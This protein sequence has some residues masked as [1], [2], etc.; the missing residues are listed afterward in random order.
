MYMIVIT[1]FSEFSGEEYRAAFV[2]ALNKW[3]DSTCIQFHLATASWQDHIEFIKSEHHGYAKISLLSRPKF[4]STKN[5]RSTLQTCIH[6]RVLCSTYVVHGIL[7]YSVV[8]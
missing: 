4:V 3:A 5:T 1:T 7:Y 6:C 8:T 2:A